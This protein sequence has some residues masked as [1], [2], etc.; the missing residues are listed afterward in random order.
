MSLWSLN[1]AY[2]PEHLLESF[3]WHDL[4]KGSVV[5]IGGSHGTFSIAIAKKYP[6][7]QF[8]VQDQP[9]VVAEGTD[10][11][12]KELQGRVSFMAH[13]FFEEQPVHGADVYLLRWILHDWSDKY[14]VKILKALL[15]ALRSGSRVLVH[16]HILPEAGGV[17]LLEER[18]LR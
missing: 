8:I 16:E 7:L 17:P 4:G 18:G 12:P 1:P 3:P 11:L 6:D 9:A 5:D 10:K 2:S 14:A 15:P 13:D